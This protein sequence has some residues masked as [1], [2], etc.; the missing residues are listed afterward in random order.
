MVLNLQKYKLRMIW[1]KIVDFMDNDITSHQCLCRL[2]CSQRNPTK[3]MNIN[4]LT[5]Q[6]EV[7]NSCSDRH[8]RKHQV[9]AILLEAIVGAFLVAIIVADGER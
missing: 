1:T 6:E 2:N 9:A 8:L 7:L 5:R 4:I 3:T